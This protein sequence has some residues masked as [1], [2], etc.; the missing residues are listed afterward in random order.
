MYGFAVVRFSVFSTNV[1]RWAEIQFPSR[2]QYPPRLGYGLTLLCIIH[3]SYRR[4]VGATCHY[5]LT[6]TLMILSL[7]TA[8]NLTTLTHSSVELRRQHHTGE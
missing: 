8:A 2:L 3:R 6:C 1:Q 7:T 5:S 4:S